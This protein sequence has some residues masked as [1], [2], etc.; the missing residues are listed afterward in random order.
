MA[1][2][3]SDAEHAVMEVLWDQSPL[4]AQDVAE[5]V[6]AERDWSANTVKTLLG[7]LLAKNVISHEEEGRRYLYRPIVAREDYVA[8]ESQR[9]IDRLFGGKL[10]PLVAHLAERDQ[11]TAQD[12]AEIE[13]LLKDLK[14]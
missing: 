8:G 12:I 6:P 9:L 14:S 13:A 5:R 1:E 2:R 11:L 3:I 4:S 7:R 10:T